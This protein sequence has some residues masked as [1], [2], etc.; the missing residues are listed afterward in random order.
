MKRARIA[1]AR[2]DPLSGDNAG[3]PQKRRRTDADYASAPDS[4]FERLPDELI[5][6]VLMAMD[7]IAAL[8]AWSLTSRRHHA[9]AMDQSLWRHLCLAHFG[10]P[11]HEP[12]WPEWV[13]WR[14]IYRAQSH[15]ASPKG[16]D[17]GAVQIKCGRHN[18]WGDVVNGK[19]HGFG[20]A[21]NAHGA[22]CCGVLRARPSSAAARRARPL[23]VKRQGH[24]IEGKMHGDCTKTYPNGTRFEGRWQRGKRPPHRHPAQR[25]GRPIRRRVQVL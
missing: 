10:P 2:G 20:I 8:A 24:W 22:H 25:I 23:I 12:P 9:L 5:L 14:W 21:V 16:A 11:L 15:P 4:L 6:H 18:Y 19:P 3:Q 17:V 7:N 1:V 13:D